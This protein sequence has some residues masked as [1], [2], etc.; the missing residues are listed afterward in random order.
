[1]LDDAV[2][3]KAKKLMEA[4]EKA[5]LESSKAFSSI[6]KVFRTS[7]SGGDGAIKNVIKA[8]LVREIPTGFQESLLHYRF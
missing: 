2:L 7:S 1:M 6:R 8:S 4:T 3:D 5:C